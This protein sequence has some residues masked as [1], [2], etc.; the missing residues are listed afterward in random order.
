MD[1]RELEILLE[2][3]LAVNRPSA[4]DLRDALVDYFVLVG[5]PFVEKGLAY[6]HPNADE[7]L[8]RRI[9]LTRLGLLWSGRCSPC[10]P[11]EDPAVQDLVVLRRRIEQY[12]CVCPAGHTP[13]L[14]KLLDDLVLAA[15][16]SERA[17]ALARLPRRRRLKLLAGGGEVSA[18]RGRL[19]LVRPPALP[20]ANRFSPLRK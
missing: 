11:W 20:E 16:I 6:T 9:L 19:A 2:A 17:Q 8:V 14:K 1:A 13:R 10:S 15:T 3:T 4:R 7:G 5:R 18:P 12:A